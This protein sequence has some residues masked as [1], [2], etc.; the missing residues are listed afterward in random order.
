MR[1]N[2]YTMKT[3]KAPSPQ[4]TKDE[5]L[6]EIANETSKGYE[7]AILIALSDGK[8]YT[9]KEIADRVVKI[10]I[11]AACEISRREGLM[12]VSKNFNWLTNWRVRLEKMKCPNCNTV[13]ELSKVKES[14]NCP[15]CGL[16]LIALAEKLYPGL[17][18]N[19][20]NSKK[21]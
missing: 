10:I 13:W 16:D 11:T 9:K 18:K 21:K 17:K 12:K 1:K 8:A 2:N 20:L 6:R 3:L 14:R 7:Y 15:V 4:N 5:V 19:R